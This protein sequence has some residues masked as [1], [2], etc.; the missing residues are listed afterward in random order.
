MQALLDLM[1]IIGNPD[2]KSAKAMT[3]SAGSEAEAVAAVDDFI[4]LLEQRLG[5]LAAEEN[6]EA[7]L[8]LSDLELSPESLGEIN[9]ALAETD[10]ALDDNLSFR[11]VSGETPITIGPATP[12][13]PIAFNNLLEAIGREPIDLQGLDAEMLQMVDAQQL[14]EDLAA[15]KTL[16][17]A[18]TTREGDALTE[19]EL[20]AILQSELS[21]GDPLDGG[22]TTDGEAGLALD[23]GGLTETD[24]E[25][26]EDVTAAG[27]AAQSVTGD[28]EDVDVEL[29]AQR[30]QRY[31]QRLLDRLEARDARLAATEEGQDADGDD[32]L[33][34]VAVPASLA[35]GS[36][37]NTGTTGPINLTAAAQLASFDGAN[38]QNRGDGQAGGRNG[39][40]SGFGALFGDDSQAPNSTMAAQ[41]N[42][43][44]PNF[45]A[46]MASTNAAKAPMSPAT[47]QVSLMVRNAAAQGQ[48]Q[49]QIQLKP[50][51]L[52]MVDVKLSFE[53]DGSVRG[54]LI[55]DRPETLEML[56]ND[57]RTL[58]RALQDAGL[59]LESGGLEFSLRDG[60]DAQDKAQDM[61]DGKASAG[62]DAIDGDDGDDAID[63][64]SQQLDIITEDQVDVR[65]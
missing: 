11:T 38:P 8:N 31:E 65:V 3:G 21:E 58:E 15:L 64:A 26:A 9:T 24:G 43:S 48:T 28:G 63:I 18:V 1:S 7:V 29:V 59:K 52:G 34:A 41:T 4:N 56:R 49:L 22:L 44:Q 20:L 10:L 60:G 47:M 50:A 5:E 53:N 46:M 6:G 13:S 45:Q 62:A 16:F 2:V 23:N 33:N 61:A 57:S 54:T 55:V 14:A 19:E 30:Q 39:G 12:P 25:S 40:N 27:L 42:S 32:G 51:S 37:A 17:A 35:T 36:G